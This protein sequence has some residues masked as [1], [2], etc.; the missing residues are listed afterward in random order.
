MA[1]QADQWTIKVKLEELDR[2]QVHFKNRWDKGETIAVQI[3]PH[4]TVSMLK[5]RVALI[6]AA[7]EKWQTL[8]VGDQ[9]LDDPA[10]RLDS[11]GDLV[12]DGS[13]VDLYAKAPAEPEED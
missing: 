2:G 13:T 6:V 1:Y 4:A 12:K 11:L 7:H 9:V 5:Q 8:K 10:A 3:E